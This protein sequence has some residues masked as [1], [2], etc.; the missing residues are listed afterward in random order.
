MVFNI[1]DI[2]AEMQNLMN[3]NYEGK[4]KVRFNCAKKD[5]HIRLDEILKVNKKD[6]I[7]Y[8]EKEE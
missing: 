6:L 4:G 1:D 5:L 7:D 8:I 2:Y 3:N